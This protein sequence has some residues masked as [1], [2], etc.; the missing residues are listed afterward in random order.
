MLILVTAIELLLSPALT[1]LAIY[2]SLEFSKP[3]QR[4]LAVVS[5]IEVV[6]Q[7]LFKTAE[8]PC[9]QR[10]LC[11]SLCVAP[12]AKFCLCALLQYVFF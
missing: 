11:S 5:S 3:H 1:S 7:V 10:A 2:V 8:R 4:C 9:F 6:P 12:P